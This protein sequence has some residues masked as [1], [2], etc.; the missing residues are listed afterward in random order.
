MGVSHN[1][2]DL[3]R[4]IEDLKGRTGGINNRTSKKMGEQMKKEV[5]NILSQE[6]SAGGSSFDSRTSNYEPGGKNDSTNSN[7]H[8]TET[9]DGKSAWKVT[10]Q[11]AGQNG[12]S[13]Y[14]FSVKPDAEYRATVI[15]YGTVGKD[16]SPEEG[17]PMFFYASGNLI[18][19]SEVDADAPA[20][21]R[22][23]RIRESLKDTLPSVR[24]VQSVRYLSRG[25]DRVRPQVRQIGR[26]ELR[27]AVQDIPNSTL[28][29]T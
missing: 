27:K 26:V 11:S 20:R 28:E 18:V 10:K 25:I 23:K 17:T 12:G 1:F 16:I 4:D 21:A 14:V 5:V 6:S 29:N 9:K 8:L 2:E 3:E 7:I 19:I 15:N 22:F 24:G 13:R